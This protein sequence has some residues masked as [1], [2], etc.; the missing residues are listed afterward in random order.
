MDYKHEV[1]QL[2]KRF[3][4]DVNK[5]RTSDNPYF[6]DSVKVQ[7]FEI[8][9]LRVELETKVAD[10]NKQFNV[11]MDSRISEL[12]TRAAKSY[13]RPS[14]TDKKLVSEF[15]SE[16]KSDVTLAYGD[17]DKLESYEKFEQKLGY[18]DE[19]GLSEVRKR[20]PEIVELLGDGDEALTSRLK[21]TNSALK[22]LR[23]TEQQQ[24]DTL[25]DEKSSGVDWAFRTLR[26]T[27]PSFADHRLNRN[28][29]NKP[30]L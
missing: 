24:L 1:E 9:K 27:H 4:N 14:E 15:I 17:R 21:A 10:V 8:S 29:P 13:F 19:H 26:M 20:L 3:R 18:L 7:D 16:L 6:A 11:E 2:V 25:L 30:S 22:Q 5:I 28:N 12:E 23:T